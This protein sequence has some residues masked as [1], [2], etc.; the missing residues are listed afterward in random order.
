MDNNNTT[1]KQQLHREFS[2]TT[3]AVDN[4][5][6]IFLLTF[7][8]LLFGTRSYINMPKE[9]SAVD[10]ENLVTRPIEKEIK[11]IS[12][13]KDFTSTSQQDFANIIVEFNTDMDIDKALQE[14]K[15]AVDKADLPNDL[16]SDPDVSDINFSEIP[17]MTVNIS[18]DLSVDELRN[19]AESL[20]EEIEALPEISEAEIKGALERE[21]QIDVDLPKMQALKLSFR[22]IESA[23]Q[24]E[25]ITMSGGEL[26]T[27]DMRRA[28]RI[29]GEFKDVSEIENIIVKSERMQPVYLR[30][31]AK[32]RMGFEERTSYARSDGLPVVSL[33]VIKRAGENLLIA[34]D[35]IKEIVAQ[36]SKNKFPEELK[37]SI[38][39]DLSIQTRDQVDNLQNS[40]ISGVIL[41]VIVLLFFLGF[42]NSLF[43]SFVDVD[44]YFDSQFDWVYLEYGGAVFA[45]SLIGDVGG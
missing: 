2:L 35:E 34:S 15:D 43:Y 12:G 10:M 14:V 36:A 4:A 41:V 7:M 23:I 33:D 1:N 3:F 32:V 6:S 29:V 13:V 30:D 31:F 18:G 17:I 21:V 24:Q 19:Y 16:P 8:I 37:V 40:I 22:D 44:G 28:L 27:G 25:N 39:N 45:D 5:T 26:Q 9:A 20:Q 42:R 38:F 11:S